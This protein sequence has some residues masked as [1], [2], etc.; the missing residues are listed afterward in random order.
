MVCWR[1][2]VRCVGSIG[3]KH[4]WVAEVRLVAAGLVADLLRSL[5]CVL[6][7]G[8][9]GDVALL[10]VGAELGHCEGWVAEVDT[11]VVGV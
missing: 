6:L 11:K 3:W 4:T 8:V 9:V 7:G 10:G 2:V 1:R 5:V